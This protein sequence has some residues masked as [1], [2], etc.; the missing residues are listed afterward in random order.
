VQSRADLPVRLPEKLLGRAPDLDA[1]QK[2]LRIGTGVLL[3]GPAGVGKT[4]LAAV[5]AADYAEQPGGVLWLNLNDDD[6][7][8]VLNRVARAYAGE[9]VSFDYSLAQQLERVRALLHEHRPL[10]VLDGQVRIEAAR[11]F[12]RECANG[13]PLLLTSPKMIAGPWTPHA[14]NAL[15]TGEVETLLTQLAGGAFSSGE[16]DATR[17]I[18]A[19]AG[20]PLAILLA[21]R[22]LANGRK[23]AQI[24]EQLPDLPAGQSNRLMALI[25]AAYRLLPPE[26]QGMMM[27]P[28]TAFSDS[29]GEELLADVSGAP[30]PAITGRMRQL[31][32]YGFV[33][34]QPGDGQPCFVAHEMIGKFAES[35]L[36][37]KQRLDAMIGRHLQA[38]LAYVGRHVADSTP[39][40]YRR[41]AAEMD[42]LMAAARYA[43]ANKKTEFLAALFQQLEPTSPESFVTACG[44]SAEYETL[45]TLLHGPDET[46]DIEPILEM[47]AAGEGIPIAERDARSAPPVRMVIE[48]DTEPKL[49][50]A[51]YEMVDKVPLTR[52][53]EAAEVLQP[54]AASASLSPVEFSVQQVDASEGFRADGDVSNE[55]AAIKSLAAQSLQSEKYE[56]VLRHVERG[57]SLAEQENNPQREGELLILLGDLQL[58]L[59]KLAGAETAYKE[60]ITALRP[61]EAWLEIGQ[62]LDKLASIYWEQERDQDAIDLWQQTIPIF[63]RVQRLDLMLDVLGKCG[64]TQADLLQWEAAQASY[65]HALTL[66]QQS[67]NTQAAFDSL[68]RLAAMFVAR[69]D[70]TSAV[71]YYRRAL[72]LAYSLPDQ[73]AL[74]RTML[75]LARLLVDDT[76]HLNRTLELLQS[77]SPLLPDDTEVQRLLKRA[78]A[79]YQRLMNAGLTLPL[80]QGS[81]TEYA[82]TAFELML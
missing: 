30:A 70:P 18:E 54:A 69:G 79:R 28:A 73:Q 19:L 64:D 38:I 40:H 49:P 78:Q 13:L 33:V 4:T 2:T 63:Q 7:L 8:S 39:E 41:L 55:L 3:H 46:P 10:I 62:T 20:M 35:F 26:L 22:Q 77:A 42:N 61:V 45:K 32:A 47:P 9:V 43:A 21:A 36:R 67:D 51:A 14:V 31:A 17:L 12:V 23:P 5:L 34:E 81:L 6:L 60:A 74:G 37:G 44:F 27:L 48:G 16:P 75:E 71:L 24:I 50:L 76:V 15:E 58:I 56:E 53:A 57:M 29:I 80:T 25:T 1:I 65:N 52:P 59:D 72:H 68:D 11:E 82:R 66:A